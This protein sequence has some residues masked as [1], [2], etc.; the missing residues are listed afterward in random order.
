[1]G[2]RDMKGAKAWSRARAIEDAL[3]THGFSRVER[4]GTQREQTM[5]VLQPRNLLSSWDDVVGRLPDPWQERANEI[6]VLAPPEDMDLSPGAFAKGRMSRRVEVP[7]GF[8]WLMKA[9]ADAYL[10]VDGPLTETLRSR[11]DSA[12]RG[13]E[14][15]T[16][17]WAWV[18]ECAQ[19]FAAGHSAPP[20][21]LEIVGAIVDFARDPQVAWKARQT[22]GHVEVDHS[23]EILMAH[24]LRFALAHEIGHHLLNHLEPQQDVVEL[25]VQQ[26]VEAW[27]ADLGIEPPGALNRDER[28]EW[29]ADAFALM[30][31]SRDVGDGVTPDAEFRR[32]TT[33]GGGAAVALLALYA[34]GESLG[35]SDGARRA[36][37]RVEERLNLVVLALTAVGRTLPEPAAIIGDN[38]IDAAAGMAALYMFGCAVVIMELLS[39]GQLGESATN[40]P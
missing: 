22:N 27:A 20:D 3:V 19:G 6:F 9:F 25:G 18:L 37:P 13:G 30:V 23:V 39:R 21:V 28:R 32:L 31:L 1:M 36:H 29:H 7:R 24:G 38:D 35:V 26:T 17:L 12:P 10:A 5:R 16:A 15:I 40:R 4:H 2:C 14:P 8:V 34:G 33:L 11:Q